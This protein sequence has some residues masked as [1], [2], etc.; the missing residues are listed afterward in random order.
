MRTTLLL[1]VLLIS[2]CQPAEAQAPDAAQIFRDVQSKYASLQ[3]YSAVGEVVSVVTTETTGPS[4]QIRHTFTIKLARPQMYRIDWEQNNQFFSNKGS[5]WSDG[6]SRYVTLAG[7]T[8]QPANTQTALAMATGV[9]GGAANTIPAIF[10]DLPSSGLSRNAN[11]VV[12]KGEERIDGDDCYVI[13]STAGNTDSTYWISK[14]TKLIRQVRRDSSGNF[15][16]PEMTDDLAR[17]TL[18]SMGRPVTDE[19]VRELQAQ[20]A[21]MQKS[22]Q[23]LKSSYSI[24][25]QHQIKINQ[26]MTPADFRDQGK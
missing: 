16:P 15:N 21:S 13:K 26:P 23:G 10:L 14:D 2:T 18:R 9:S 7:Q 12:L 20:M 1:S 22:I 25:T 3:S 5:V 24:E 11:G 8:S 17:Q 19:A 6:E 4:Q